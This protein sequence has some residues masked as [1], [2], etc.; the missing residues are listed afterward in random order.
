MKVDRE[1]EDCSFFRFLS[2]SGATDPG[3]VQ[4]I[5][6]QGMGK[7]KRG[8]KGSTVKV[9]N[10]EKGRRGGYRCKATKNWKDGKIS[11]SF[12]AAGPGW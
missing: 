10:A 2:F 9:R 5:Q 3:H 7:E 12:V 6:D 1:C 4:I 8:W 11:P